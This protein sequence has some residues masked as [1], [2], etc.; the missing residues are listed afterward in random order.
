MY[1]PTDLEKWISERFIKKAIFNPSDLKIYLMA[2]SFDITHESYNG[3]AISTTDEF[4]AYI[5]TDIRESKEIQIEQF[6]H[7]LGH[8]LR[9]S[10]DQNK[11]LDLFREKQEWDA[12]L[13]TLYA[14]IP[15]HMI[16]FTISNT[17][18]SL[19]DQFNV[20]EITAKKRFKQIK[21]QLYYSPLNIK[22]KKHK[23]DYSLDPFNIHKY[24]DEA[25]RLIYQLNNQLGGKLL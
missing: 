15:Y 19:R 11:M 25:K 7:E 10:G 12:H 20:S 3:K 1:I 21:Q 14:L 9:H 22:E 23:K 18:K 17:V 8:T 4:G 24:S 6:F 13:F 5:L 2:Q 16:D